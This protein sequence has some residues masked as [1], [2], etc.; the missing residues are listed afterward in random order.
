MS[1]PPR[2]DAKIVRDAIGP[3]ADTQASLEP[4]FPG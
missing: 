1:L 3:Y 2:I 4:A